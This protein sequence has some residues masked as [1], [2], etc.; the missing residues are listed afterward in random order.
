VSG[1]SRYETWARLGRIRTAETMFAEASQV[2]E[3]AEWRGHL[4]KDP[5]GA[6]WHSS[7]HASRFPGDDAR[8]CTRMLQYELLGIPPVEP[9]SRMLRGT[10]VV[11]Q[12]AEDWNVGNLD[13]DGRL[14]TPSH[15]ADH[16][17]RF[18]DADHW[19]SGS[20]DM[21]VLPKG[22]NRPHYIETKTKDLEVVVEMKN[23]RRSYDAK[24]G[25]QCRTIIGLGNR[26]SPILWSR[27]VICRHTWRLAEPGNE[28]VI[29]A[30]ICRDHGIN[31]DCGCLI[32]LELEPLRT[33]SLIYMGRDR[34]HVTCEYVFEHD[35]QWF[36]RGL[37]AIDRVREYFERG[38][39]IPHP[40]GGKG[41]SEPPCKYCDYKRETCKPDNK[42]NVT[43]LS[44]TH[45]IG[46]AQ[47]I[48]GGYSIENTMQK[49]LDRWAG[50]SGVAAEM[51]PVNVNGGRD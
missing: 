37:E 41:W 2:A 7:F 42:A 12:A 25:R 23:L 6:A 4:T 19:L 36:R 14:L 16:Q 21:V 38:E 46:W 47:K 39:L 24:H 31:D 1:L 8:T 10:M 3:D 48:Y 30:M 22:W 49:V 15:T 18:E 28:S 44:E 29:D 50:R 32:E 17:M 34:P 26:I 20:P 51:P 11:G 33:G 35:E 5:H 40:F 45:G 43:D 27:V 13:I 9:F